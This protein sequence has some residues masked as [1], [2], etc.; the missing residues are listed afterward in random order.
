MSLQEQYK[1]GF[2]EFCN[3]VRTLPLLIQILVKSIV[4]IWHVIF[5]EEDR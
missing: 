5:F 1:K 4:S 3:I 2:G